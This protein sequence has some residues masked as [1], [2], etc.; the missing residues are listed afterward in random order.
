MDPKQFKEWMEV[1]QSFHGQD[2]WKKIFDDQYGREMME[3]VINETQP[4]QQTN[5]AASEDKGFP[6][7]ELFKNRDY[8]VVVIELPGVQKG[9]VDLSFTG[10]QLL[11]RG[12]IPSLRNQLELVHSNRHVGE[13]E[14]TIHLP[15][16]PDQSDIEAQF[17]NGLLQVRIRRSRSNFT[18]IQ[19]K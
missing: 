11:V 18:P 3:G 7:Y 1:A 17:N 12:T 2:F 9:D 8:F 15:D 14:R 19:I 10:D 16:S 6:K 13:F 4:S 5:Q